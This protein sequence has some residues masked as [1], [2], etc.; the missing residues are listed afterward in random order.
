MAKLHDPLAAHLLNRV[1]LILR[2]LGHG[3]DA[4]DD[5]QAR[6]ADLLDSMGMVE[7]LAVVAEDL[8]VDPEAIEQCVAG[9][10]GTVAELASS[11]NAAGLVLPKQQVG[12]GPPLEKTRTFARPAD[13]PPSGQS[14]PAA[15]CWLTAA[16]IRLP[17]KVQPAAAINEALHRPAG[18]WESHAGI[19]DRRTWENQDPIQAAVEAGRGC[20]D[21]AG[22]AAEEIGALLVTAEAPPLLAGLAAALHHRLDLRSSA[23]A[24]EVGGACTGFLAALWLGRALLPRLGAVLVMAVEAPTRFLRLQPGPA[25]EAAAL[26]GDGAAACLLCDRSQDPSDVAVADIVLGVDGGQ[27][28]LIRVERSE[29]GPIEVQL[30]GSPLASQAIQVMAQSVRELTHGHG[31]RID[32]LQAVVAHGG[33]GRLPALLARQLGLPPERVWSETPRTG[34]LGSASLPVAWA[35]RYPG[36]QG[37]VVWTAVGAGLTWAAAL[38]V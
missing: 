32:D 2:N 35:S 8:G 1:G 4:P 17:E 28:H 3:D 20:L 37:P 22:L 36:P 33:N 16:A 23:P 26:F 31:L 24:L 29:A 25:G 38:F 6:F 15:R 19:A 7:F 11:L 10:F 12:P 34:N 27:G 21:R 5:A 14:T 18:W 13:E 30:E 9:R